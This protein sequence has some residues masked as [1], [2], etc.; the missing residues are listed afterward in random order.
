MD[1]KTGEILAMAV[2]PSFD[3]NN[4]SSY[5]TENRRNIAVVDQ[6]EP[7]S[8]FKIVTASAALDLGVVTPTTGFYDPGHIKIGWSDCTMLAGRRAT[9]R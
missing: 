1:P 6:Y 8:T 2:Y 3:P 7:G 9:G 5:P 4:Y